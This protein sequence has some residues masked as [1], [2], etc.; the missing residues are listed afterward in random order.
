ML[1]ARSTEDYAIYLLVDIGPILGVNP[2]K[3]RGERGLLRRWIEAGDQRLRRAQ[4]IIVGS[5]GALP[6]PPIRS[7]E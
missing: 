4:L 1:K 3:K 5:L 2:F 6:R 7:R